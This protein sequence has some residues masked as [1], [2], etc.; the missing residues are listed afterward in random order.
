MKQVH[1]ECKPDELLVS[2]LSFTRKFI[3][4]HQGKSKVFNKLIKSESLLAMVDEDP[5]SVKTSYEKSLR[6]EEESHGIKYYSDTSDNKV[7]VL[8]GKLEDWIITVC[9]NAKIKPTD[10]G[11]PT[12]SN[13]LHDVINQRLDKFGKLIEE[14]LRQDCP[15][16]LKL[17]SWMK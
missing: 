15:A 13:D 9:S 3:T 11:L 17:K 14:L 4:H 8:T 12:K 16:V 6:L 2:K 5:G 7:L 1:I 10:F